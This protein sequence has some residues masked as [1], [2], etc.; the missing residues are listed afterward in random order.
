MNIVYIYVSS[1][2]FEERKIVSRTH[3]FAKTRISE[4]NCPFALVTNI[5]DI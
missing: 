2:D 3:S 4:P 5:L 1:S